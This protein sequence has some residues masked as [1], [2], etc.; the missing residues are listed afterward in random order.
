MKTT[1]ESMGQRLQAWLKYLEIN[2][3]KAAQLTEIPRS[4]WYQWTGEKQA[5][6]QLDALLKIMAVWPELNEEWLLTGKGRMV[7]PTPKLQLPSQDESAKIEEE[8]ETE[9]SLRWLETQKGLHQRFEKEDSTGQARLLPEALKLL[10][11]ILKD[12]AMKIK[13]T[14]VYVGHATAFPTT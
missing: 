10:S 13:E 8:T 4:N 14:D 2:P 1:Q 11:E 6:P 9:K 3:N 12:T 5:V 7:R